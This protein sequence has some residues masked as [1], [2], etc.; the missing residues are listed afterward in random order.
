MILDGKGEKKYRIVYSFEHK[1]ILYLRS[2]FTE[3][4]ITHYSDKAQAEQI[5]RGVFAGRFA[6]MN[7]IQDTCAT[8]VSIE[9][10]YGSSSFKARRV[11]K[12]LDLSAD[13]NQWSPELHFG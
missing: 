7:E 2:I 9:E 13:E 12:D 6:D 10:D 1:E 3:L 5:V 4:T 11:E 8:N